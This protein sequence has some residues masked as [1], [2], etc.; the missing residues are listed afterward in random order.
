MCLP[1]G[2]EPTED[3]EATFQRR[4]SLDLS[5]GPGLMEVIEVIE[6]IIGRLNTASCSL[7]V[8][9]KTVI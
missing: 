1:L 7:R 9:R 4:H 2:I 8:T 5:L 3:G 6:G